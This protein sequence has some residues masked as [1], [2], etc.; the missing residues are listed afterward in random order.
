K[1]GP[2]CIPAPFEDPA[3]P[4][5]TVEDVTNNDDGTTSLSAISRCDQSGGQTPCWKLEAKPMCPAVCASD[6][7][8][9]QHFSLTI[10]RSPEGQLPPNTA[11]RSICRVLNVINPPVCGAP[12]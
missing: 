9:G 3:N 6:G 2:G 7:D 5:C 1:L 10:D 8:P 11:V 12:L 4:D